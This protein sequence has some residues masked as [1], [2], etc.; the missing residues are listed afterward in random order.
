MLLGSLILAGGRSRRMGQPKESLPFGDTTLLGRTADLL[1]ECTWPMLVVAR[2]GDQELPPLPPELPVVHDDQPD[3]GPLAAIAKGLRHLRAG[4]E[5]GER[6]AV[7]VTGCDAPWLTTGAIAWLAG[8]LGT[9]Q[10]V[11]PRAGGVLQPLCAV[12]R[13]DCLPAIES[14]LQSGVDTPRTIA[15]KTDTLVL[16]E[17]ALRRFDPE[18]RFLRNLNTP[19]DYEAARRELGG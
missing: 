4:K 15:E 3:R 18:L 1:L 7:F 10:A 6:D 17:E 19:A 11:V 9:R 8:Q 13:A 5:L 16:E 12:Y 14:L 2:G